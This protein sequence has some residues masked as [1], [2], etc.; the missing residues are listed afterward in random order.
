MAMHRISVYIML[1]NFWRYH[2]PL[3]Y[4]ATGAEIIA[5]KVPAKAMKYF[6]SGTFI[7]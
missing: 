6:L 3:Y 4:I 7:V 5:L 2:T 1:F